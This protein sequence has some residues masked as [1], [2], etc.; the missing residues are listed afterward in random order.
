MRLL[1]TDLREGTKSVH[2]A[3]GRSK[4]VNTLERVLEDHM[5]NAQLDLIYFPDQLARKKILEQDLERFHG[6]QWR[7]LIVTTSP[8]QQKYI[9][10][11]EHCASSATPELLIAHSYVRYMGDLSG[12]Q[13]I[14]KRLKSY[15]VG[16]FTFDKI[17]D[18]DLFKELFRKRLNQVQISD[19]LKDKIVEEAIAA[20]HLNMEI[21][22]EFDHELEGMPMTEE[23]QTKEL[24]SFQK[25][26]EEMAAAKVD[27][28]MNVHFRTTSSTGN[29]D[30]ILSYLMPSN[31]WESLKGAVGVKVDV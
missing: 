14:A 13:I 3:A 11:I 7:D 22:S 29:S 26:K 24:A 16:F 23:E 8:A 2:T 6:P 5:K 30:G 21:F 27:E 1:S 15:N 31:L 17:E 10:A 18:Y 4:F 19:E 9:A 25:E 28:K 20:F 12:G